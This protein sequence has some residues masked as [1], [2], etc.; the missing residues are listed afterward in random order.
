[1]PNLNLLCTSRQQLNDEYPEGAHS[2]SRS[3]MHYLNN[4]LFSQGGMPCRQNRK[5]WIRSYRSCLHSRSP[6]FDLGQMTLS[7]TRFCGFPQSVFDNTLKQIP[8][9]SFQ[10]TVTTTSTASGAYP[11]PDIV[12]SVTPYIFKIHY[13]NR[14]KD[15]QCL[16]LKRSLSFRISYNYDGWNFNSGNYLFTTDTK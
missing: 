3:I 14:E 12:S 10:M 4:L 11:Q 7:G 9:A 1:M 5:T 6:G 15:L 13:N 16:C 8:C 2:H